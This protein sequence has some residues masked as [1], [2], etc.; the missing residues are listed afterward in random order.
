[1]GGDDVLVSV[2]A[3]VAWRFATELG[4]EFDRLRSTWESRLQD[5]LAS[6]PNPQ[7]E[8]T[9][10]DLIGQVSLGIGM[11]IAHSSHPIA[12]SN[13]VAEQALRAAKLS[14]GVPRAPSRGSTSPQRV[15]REPSAMDSGGR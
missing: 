5:D 7:L 10:K 11:V 2:P 15:S 8:A 3:A 14:T 1:M 13:A 6:A 4:W 9:M 12:D